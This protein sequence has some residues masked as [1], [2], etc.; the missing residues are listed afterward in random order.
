MDRVLSPW[1]WEGL[2]RDLIDR[3]NATPPP[4]RTKTPRV[5]R[6]PAPLL[7]RS[8]FFLRACKHHWHSAVAIRTIGLNTFTGTRRQGVAHADVWTRK[9]L[10]HCLKMRLE[11][12]TIE[13]VVRRSDVSLSTGSLQK[14]TWMYSLLSILRTMHRSW[15]LSPF[16]CRFQ[17][18]RQTLRR[19]LES[20]TQWHQHPR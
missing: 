15:A 20:A 17:W 6:L 3:C 1:F 8:S 16:H 11:R 2:W 12:G 18:R 9:C 19:K 7:P 5:F 13:I 4:C 10:I 14:R